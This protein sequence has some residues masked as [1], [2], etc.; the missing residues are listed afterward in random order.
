MIALQP[1]E[2]RVSITFVRAC[3]LGGERAG[4]NVGGVDVV[5]SGRVWSDL[6][7]QFAANTNTTKV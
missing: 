4:I 7:W 6:V 2:W 3:I 1:N 5:A